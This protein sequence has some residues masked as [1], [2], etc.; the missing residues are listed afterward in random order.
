MVDLHFHNTTG[1]H[2]VLTSVAHSQAPHSHVDASARLS[3][4]QAGYNTVCDILRAGCRSVLVPFAAG[5]E[6][7]QGARAERLERLGL[8]T[9][10]PEAGLGAGAMTRAVERA[11]SAPA[12]GPAAL[13]LGGAARTARLLVGLAGRQG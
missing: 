6:T 7:E 1:Q 12:P 11:L 4:S 8:A 3:I 2:A 13:D 9:V 5:G 10:L